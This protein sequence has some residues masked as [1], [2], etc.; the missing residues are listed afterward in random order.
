MSEIIDVIA[1][2]DLT[3]ARGKVLYS[4]GSDSER[5]KV[6]GA[7]GN[8][9]LLGICVQG[10]ADEGVAK[11]C[12]DGFCTGIAGGALEPHDFVTSNASGL[13]VVAG[14]QNDYILGQYLPPL[15]G[16][17]QRD[18]AANDEVRIKVFANKRVLVP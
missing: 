16:G 9:T 11:V 1:G 14:S 7:A 6:A 12:I 13:I 10:A 4:D 5:A 18:A 2:A 17:T 15:E 3:A 8:A